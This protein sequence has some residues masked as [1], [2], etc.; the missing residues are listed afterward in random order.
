M[1]LHQKKKVWRW[2]KVP[3]P[4]GPTDSTLCVH[5]DVQTP[6][7]QTPLAIEG[8]DAEETMKKQL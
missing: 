5:E 8:P 2:F 3:F 7:Y 1:P 6:G 4:Y